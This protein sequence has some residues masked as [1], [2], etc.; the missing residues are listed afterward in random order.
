MSILITV[1][2]SPPP[3]PQTGDIK[4]GFP[5]H[6]RDRQARISRPFDATETTALGKTPMLDSS[7]PTK[8]EETD[9]LRELPE[10]GNGWLASLPENSVLAAG[11]DGHWLRW[12]WILGLWVIFHSVGYLPASSLAAW[13]RLRPGGQSQEGLWPLLSTLAQRLSSLHL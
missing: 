2:P 5:G 9:R 3:T 8:R 11:P 10:R 12:R 6:T 13:P 4:I 7:P 1:P